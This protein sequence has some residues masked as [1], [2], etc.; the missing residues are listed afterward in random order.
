MGNSINSSI[1]DYCI[2]AS[3]STLNS[4]GLLSEEEITLKG[5]QNSVTSM[6][7]DLLVMFASAQLMIANDIKETEVIVTVHAVRLGSSIYIT[8]TFIVNCLVLFIV[9]EEALRTRGWKHLTPFNYTDL[10]ALAAAS[11]R[12]G[13]ELAAATSSKASGRPDS[14]TSISVRQTRAGFSLSIA[15]PAEAAA[16]DR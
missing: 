6:T 8:A 16:T 1:A 7:D 15:L 10:G 12:G 11:S 5:L 14:S 3:N 13:D 4:G 9:L 2:F